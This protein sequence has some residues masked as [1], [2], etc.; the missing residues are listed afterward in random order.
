MDSWQC[1][2]CHSSIDYIDSDIRKR[3]LEKGWHK[4]RHCQNNLKKLRINLEDLDALEPEKDEIASEP[5][6]EVDVISTVL[7]ESSNSIPISNQ[8]FQFQESLLRKYNDI[9]D[10]TMS[11]RNGSKYSW[12]AEDLFA[13]NNARVET[14]LS[15]VET[16]RWMSVFEDILKRKNI[17]GVVLPKSFKTIATAC[18]GGIIGKDNDLHHLR[19]FEWSLGKVDD[20]FKDAF[21]KSQVY[22]SFDILEVIGE[23]LLHCDPNNFICNPDCERFSVAPDGSPSSTS[24]ILEDYTTCD[25]FKNATNKLREETNESSVFLGIQVRQDE[26]TCRSMKRS[27]MSVICTTS[28]N[29]T[30]ILRL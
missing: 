23:A 22:Y 3:G 19:Q 13:I 8:I 26:T 4:R 14:N 27:G 6:L 12:S 7:T 21:P 2:N 29:I 28:S 10:K 11:R 25:H 5:N 30:T 17:D 20:R 9:L 1:S 24:R 16:E 18:D 15:S